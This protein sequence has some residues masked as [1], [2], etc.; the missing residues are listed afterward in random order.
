MTRRARLFAW[1][2]ALLFLGALT[3]LGLLFAHRGLEAADQLSSV[4]GT[5]VGVTGLALSVYGTVSARRDRQSSTPPMPSARA[6]KVSN[7]VVDTRVH[8]DLTQAQRF[9]PTHGRTETDSHDHGGDTENRITGGSVGGSVI[10]ARDVHGTVP[11][12]DDN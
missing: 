2:G 10:Q 7:T 6:G 11:A 3:G 9:G 8:G 12:E 4:L 5:F 1:A